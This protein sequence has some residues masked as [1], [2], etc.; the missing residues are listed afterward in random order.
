MVFSY[1]F[2]KNIDEINVNK[3]EENEGMYELR[4][5]YDW[6]LIFKAISPLI[7]ISIGAGLTIPFVNLFFNSVFGFTSSSFSMLG[8]FT[9]FLVFVFSL[10]VPTLRKKYGYWM[11]IVVVQ[12]VAIVC[13]IV[14]SLTEIYA[15]HSM[16]SYNSCCC[17]YITTAYDAYGAPIFKRINDELRW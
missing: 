6:A 3:Y 5:S 10:M 12:S 14:M 4:N 11:T 8:S 9:A 1:I 16:R 2:T 15:Y 17:V 7:L 13:L